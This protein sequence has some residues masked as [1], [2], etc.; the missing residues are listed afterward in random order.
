MPDPDMLAAELALGLIEGEERASALR[1]VLAEPAFAAEVEAWRAH[2][3]VMF[4]LSPEI[5]APVNGLARIE[6]ALSPA[7]NDGGS[8]LTIWRG[9]AAASLVAVAILAVVAF[10]PQATS[11]VAPPVQVAQRSA[12]L[13]AQIIPVDKSQPVP[14]VFDPASGEL[15]IAAAALVS[16]GHSPELWV[17]AADGVPHS[18][19]VL[20]A[21]RSTAVTIRAA[22]R[23]RFVA[24]SA[25]VV[26]V[27]PVGGSPSGKP[28]GAVVAQ[29]P[30]TLV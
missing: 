13:V 18:L 7:A 21:Q 15:R 25:L 30:L 14:A 6:R 17:I 23:A 3:G 10:G 22:D 11:P 16:A 24:G 5:A 9:M 12:V 1:R 2:L 20:H 26:T 27:E 29:G 19:G 8:Q 28:T 4:D